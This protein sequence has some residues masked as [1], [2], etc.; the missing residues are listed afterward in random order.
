M[1]NNTV[2]AAFAMRDKFIVARY[3][4][5]NDCTVMAAPKANKTEMN[6]CWF[7]NI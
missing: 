2:R 7:Y 1:L 6:V 4:T 5:S 3:S